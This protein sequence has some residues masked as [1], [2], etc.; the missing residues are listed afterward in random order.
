MLNIISRCYDYPIIFYTIEGKKSIN[1]PFEN[2][3]KQRLPK[4]APFGVFDQSFVYESR[5]IWRARLIAVV[6]SR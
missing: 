1:K 4:K 2:K 3:E 5:A 6:R